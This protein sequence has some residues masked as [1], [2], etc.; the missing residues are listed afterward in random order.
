MSLP[1][2]FR[3]PLTWA[4]SFLLLA[5]TPSDCWGFCSLLHS[6]FTS[7]PQ[8]ND[9]HW[10]WPLTGLKWRL[11]FPQLPLWVVFCFCFPL[12]F[13]SIHSTAFLH[14]IL[15]TTVMPQVWHYLVY[16]TAI[17]VQYY[18]GRALFIGLALCSLHSSNLGSILCRAP[19]IGLA[20]RS[21]L[22]KLQ[23]SNFVASR[24]LFVGSSVAFSTAILLRLLI[25]RTV[26]V[27][28]EY[29]VAFSTAIFEQISLPSFLYATL[30]MPFK[31]YKL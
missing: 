12:S 11:S 25:P 2:F 6:T 26:F 30:L 4:P 18:V 24:V 31:L 17:L 28:S 15:T 19:F 14:V 16:S 23:Y 20:L 1:L 7:G 27:D 5:P 9:R 8:V 29:V 22:A 10:H 3:M 21:L 13:N